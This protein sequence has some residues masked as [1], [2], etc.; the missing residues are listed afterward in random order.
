MN[1][2]R[3]PRDDILRLAVRHIGVIDP[4]DDGSVTTKLPSCLLKDDLV[5]S[6]W[7]DKDCTV[8]VLLIKDIQEWCMQNFYGKWRFVNG[9]FYINYPSHN[10]TMKY[11][12]AL[13]NIIEFKSETDRL[14][15]RFRWL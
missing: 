14:L 4:C 8:R 15:F 5:K 12:P 13:L 3:V 6:S 11:V 1:T 2:I 9:V 7:S 10:G